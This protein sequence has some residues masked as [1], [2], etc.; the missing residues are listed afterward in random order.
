MREKVLHTHSPTANVHMT[1]LICVGYIENEASKKGNEKTH[2]DRGRERKE[3][4]E[5][6]E[7]V[8]KWARYRCAFDINQ[9]TSTL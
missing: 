4:L 2:C 3:L 7:I 5:L 1:R 6:F 8:R 9:E